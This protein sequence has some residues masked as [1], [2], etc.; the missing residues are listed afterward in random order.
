MWT[1]SGEGCG[2]QGC[3][4][5][6]NSFTVRAVWLTVSVTSVAWNIRYSDI[7]AGA[8][9]TAGLAAVGVFGSQVPRYISL[10]RFVFRCIWALAAD[11]AQFEWRSS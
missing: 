1:Q 11:N 4:G 7:Y 8:I 5:V 3:V 9:L 2:M 10:C 6:R